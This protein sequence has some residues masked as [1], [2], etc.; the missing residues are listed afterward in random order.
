MNDE[1]KRTK[2]G[3]IRTKSKKSAKKKTTKKPKTFGDGEVLKC[4]RF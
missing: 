2:T 3:L 4:K 1:V